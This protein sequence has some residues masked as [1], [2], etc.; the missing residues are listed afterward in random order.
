MNTAFTNGAGRNERKETAI[1]ELLF[2]YGQLFVDDDAHREYL[3]NIKYA[4]GISDERIQ[5][6]I[7][8]RRVKPDPSAPRPT[9]PA[10]GRS[11]ESPELTDSQARTMSLLRMSVS[12]RGTFV[13]DDDIGVPKKEK[14]PIA[15]AKTFPKFPDGAKLG[16]HLNCWSSPP[17]GNFM[18]RGPKYLKNKKKVPSSDYLFP[19]RGCDLFLTDLAPKNLGRNRAILEGKLREKPT[20]IVN[21]RLPW[22]VFLSYHEI[23][24]RFLP[25]LRRGHGHG[26]QSVPLPS[27]AGMTAGDRAACNFLL[28]DS[29]EKD[30]AW[31][32][33][34]V[35]AQGPWMVKKVV[36]GKPAIVGKQL[37]IT[38]VYQ[39]AQ[40]MGNDE[41]LCE[42]LE[43]DLDIVSSAA[44]RNILAVVRSYTNVLTVDLGFVVQGNKKEELPEQMMLG[45][46]LHGLDPL[47]AE[48]LPEMDDEGEEGDGEPGLDDEDGN[49]TE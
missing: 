13:D 10:A 43:A 9:L 6:A 8:S 46:R 32:I 38:Y 45:L 22:G 40:K 21:Y 11:A 16:S 20:F 14:K 31:K 39:P 49:M 29:E 47:T 5:Q 26:D 24:E 19:C 2:S 7:Q 12:V 36:G 37:P 17:S 18:V 1:N 41:E 35:V 34:P 27:T 28:S 25:F 30:A 33:V 44:A 23:P 15:P 4:I 3:A 48:L 42:Y